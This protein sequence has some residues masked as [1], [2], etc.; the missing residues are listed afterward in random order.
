MSSVGRLGVA[1][2]VVAVATALSP[3]AHPQSV[4]D[5]PGNAVGINN[6]SSG[7][8]GEW[9]RAGAGF[10][11]AVKA[12]EKLEPNS[13]MPD[14]LTRACTFLGPF[15]LGDDARSV[16]KALG[17]PHRTLPQPGGATASAYFLEQAGHYPYLV[18]TVA[19]NR[20]VALQVTGPVAAKGYSFN[21]V[22]LGAGTDTLVEYFGQPNHLEPSS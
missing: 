17:A 10:A 15:A 13:A 1:L 20:I 21:H 7:L 18:V 3:A 2:V 9:R 16:T 22:D 12:P 14:V 6:T 5:K 4:A 19:K 11:C 8:R